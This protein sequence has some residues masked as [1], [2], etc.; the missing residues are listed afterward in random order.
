MKPLK[1]AATLFL[2]AA[3]FAAAPADK[4]PVLPGPVP[5]AENQKLATD[6][7][8][9]IIAIR[10]VHD[11]GTRQ[12]AEVMVR[13]LKQGG[14]APGDIVSLADPKYPHQ[15]N[16]V[17]RLKGKGKAKPILYICHMDIVEAKA[18]DWSK[19]PF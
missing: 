18:S 4:P 10:S 9:D 19:P 2:A 16:V 8:R 15:M 3:S 5:P 13:Y 12:V 1:L 7:L 11:V 17:V 14:F 6:I